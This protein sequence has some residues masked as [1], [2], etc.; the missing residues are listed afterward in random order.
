MNVKKS[1][2]TYRFKPMNQPNNETS[3]RTRGKTCPECGNRSLYLADAFTFICFKFECDA[4][5]PL[6]YF[7][8]EEPE[9]YDI[10]G[11]KIVY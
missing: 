5:F 11:D 7:I 8:E 1:G 10:D 2:T 3:D 9:L 4:H 6:E